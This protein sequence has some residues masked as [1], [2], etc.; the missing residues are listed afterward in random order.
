MKTDKTKVKRLPKRGHYD[1][2]SIYRIL[3]DNFLCHVGFQHNG[4]PVVIPTAYGREDDNIFIHGSSASRM[5]KDLS[6]GIECCLC[7]SKVNALV[8]AKSGFHHSMNYESVV[9]FGKAV[10]LI[11][12]KEKL[13]ALK[14]ITDNILPGRWDEARLP[15][16]LEMKATSVLK[17]NIEEA[18]A[19]IRTGMPSDDPADDSLQIWSG[20]LPIETKYSA[21]IAVDNSIDIPSS[22][23]Y[24]NSKS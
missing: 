14:I 13:K 7:V 4:F 18:S 8:L 17:I 24:A 2:P 3:D 9:V 21:A 6:A 10:Q 22:V 19:K 20:L 12:E 11:D 1:K 15:S 23:Q 5:Q 16:A